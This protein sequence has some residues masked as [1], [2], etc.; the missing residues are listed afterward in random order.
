[1]G[2]AVTD[3]DSTAP[4]PQPDWSLIAMIVNGTINVVRIAIAPRL[5]HKGHEVIIVGDYV[6]HPRMDPRMFKATIDLS[7]AAAG[8]A[9][10][11]FAKLKVVVINPEAIFGVADMAIEATRRKLSSAI[12]GPDGN[13]QVEMDKDGTIKGDINEILSL[14]VS[15]GQPPTFEPAPEG[16]PAPDPEP[17]IK[18]DF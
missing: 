12:I 6:F 11:G 9:A 16:S 1:M 5:V 17:E 18:L 7:C 2:K 4:A 15:N 14:S 8:R 3:R 10:A 13:R